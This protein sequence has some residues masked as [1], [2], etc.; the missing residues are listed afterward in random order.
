MIVNQMYPISVERREVPFDLLPLD[1]IISFCSD[2]H[3]NIFLVS[4]ET[5]YRYS[6]NLSFSKHLFR[7]QPVQ[8]TEQV[9]LNYQFTISSNGEVCNFAGK[10][11]Q[12]V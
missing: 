8:D 6:A 7:L 5:H 3:P 4:H 9:L 1:H 2:P 10:A 12:E 11:P